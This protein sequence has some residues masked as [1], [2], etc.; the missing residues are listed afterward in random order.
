MRSSLCAAVL[1]ALASP[2][3]AQQVRGVAMDS[4]GRPVAGVA[5]EIRA[6]T[7][8]VLPVVSTDSVGRF[9]FTLPGSGT[10]ELRATRIGYAAIGPTEL[11][12]D[13]GQDLE[14]VLRLGTNAIAL[15]PVEVTVRAAAMSRT[16]EVRNRIEW[17]R[18]IGVGSTLTREEIEAR[19][20]P[21]L[22]ALV[23]SMSSRVRTVAPIT[24]DETIMLASSRSEWGVCIPYFYIDGVRVDGSLET[25]FLLPEQLEAVE[26]YHGGAQAPSEYIGGSECGVVLFWTRSGVDAGAPGVSWKRIALGGAIAAFILFVGVR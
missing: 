6:R 2:G 18:R 8:A 24:G 21:T 1:L 16:E 12:A 17:Q 5:V 19:A 25:S 15:A 7:G 9:R 26:L 22:A 13:R 11:V 3:T 4:A 20:A 10:Y 23:G 14:I